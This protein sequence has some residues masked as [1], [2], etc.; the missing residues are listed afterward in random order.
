MKKRSQIDEKMKWDLTKFVKNEEEFSSRLSRLKN[1]SEQIAKF[2]NKLEDENKLLECLTLEG[3]L[4]QEIEILGVFCFCKLSEDVTNTQ[5][6]EL[7]QKF[8]KVVSDISVALAFVN[9]EISCFSNEK[10]EKLICNLQFENYKR[11]FEQT[12]KN[13]KYV[14]SKKEEKLLS[15]MSF[16]NGFSEGFDK[17][18]DGDLKFGKVKDS[19]G[20]EYELSHSVYS[21]LLVHPDSVLRRNVFIKLNSTYGKYKNFLSSNYI[22]EVKSNCYFAK[23]RGFSSVLQSKIFYEEASEKTYEMLIEKV[24]KNLDVFF[25]YME[26]KRKMLGLNKICISDSFAPVCKNLEKKFT[27]YEAIE[28][29]KEACAPLGEE[30]VSLIQKAKDE[31]WVDVLPNQGKDSGAFSIHAFGVT[32]MLLTNF[33]GNLESVFTLSHELGHAI[34]SQYSMNVQ[35]Y[36]TSNY[37]I[38]VAEVA[39]TTNEILLLLHFL[40][41]AKTDKEKIYYY[42]KL[43][44]QVKST[45]FRQTMFSQFEHKVHKSYENDEPLTKEMLCDYYYNLN[46]KYF[47]KKVEVLKEIQYEW[48]RIPHFYRSFYVYK[49][50]TGLI[51]AINFAHELLNNNQKTREK[52]IKFLSSGSCQSPIKILQD[53]GCNLEEDFAFDNVFNF[54]KSIVEKWKSLI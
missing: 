8:D 41:K 42:D 7:N 23:V 24:E 54:L 28:I 38:F 26:I 46:K 27:Y 16:L 32:P 35:P 47:G 25:E 29:I 18:N 40:S 2:E 9:V 50:A 39:S 14:L 11:Y 49:Y 52:Y 13:K 36:Q 22:N 51:C 44:T 48:M 31:R 12:L 1:K 33:T 17:F 19:K 45:I 53:A 15:G 3:E 20:K 21:Q 43:F 10:L 4:S 37:A 30:Y 5:A 6:N 34:H